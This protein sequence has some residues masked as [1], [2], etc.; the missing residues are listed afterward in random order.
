MNELSRM[1]RQRRRAASLSLRQLAKESGISASH[2]A[3]IER[4]NRSPSARTLHRIAQPLGLDEK[5]LFT[6]SGFLSSHPSDDIHPDV[7]YTNSGLDPYVANIVA[8]EP[9]DVQHALVSI[10]RILKSLANIIK[11]E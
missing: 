6:L 8:Q 9:Y 11:E 7:D 10:L 2:L 4:G 1:I 3:R 5:R